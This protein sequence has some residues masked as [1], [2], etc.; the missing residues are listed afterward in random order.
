MTDDTQR[1]IL[2]AYDGSDCADVAIDKVG[3]EFAGRKVVILV[4]SEQLERVPFFGTAGIP[5]EPETMELLTD[6]AQKG[7]LE[8]A[9]K[10]ADRARGL[11]L[12]PTTE[13][14]EGSPTWSKIVDAAEE[15]D[16]AL[17]AIGSRGLSGI[18][19]AVLGS[20]S[21]AVSQH[22]RRSVLIAHSA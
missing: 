20:V 2:I 19:H 15:H 7:A 9:Q 5:V 17:I 8:I 12:D 13:V 22:S 14:A 1:P 16:A 10:G 18:K 4:V 11:G 6:A 3:A 21:G